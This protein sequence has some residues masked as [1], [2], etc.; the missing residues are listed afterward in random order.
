MYILYFICSSVNG[1]FGCFHLL[2]IVNAVAVNM[3]VQ[4]SVADPDFNVFEYPKLGL[5]D[6]TAVLFLTFSGNSI[7]FSIAAATF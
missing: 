1:H 4:I 6:N 2:A 7:L 3:G 5:L